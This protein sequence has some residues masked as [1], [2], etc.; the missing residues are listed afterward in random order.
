MRRQRAD[1]LFGL[2]WVVL[3]M[4]I[5]IGSWRMDRLEGQG[6]EPYAVPGLLPGMLGALLAAFGMA[7]ALRGWRGAGTAEAP[8]GA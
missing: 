6:V 5:A 2:G 3:G 1:Q 4:A 8:E 7:L